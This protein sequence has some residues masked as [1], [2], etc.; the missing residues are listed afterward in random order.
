M[1]LASLLACTG[2]LPWWHE[3]SSHDTSADTAEDLCI[4]GC[5]C[6]AAAIT[7]GGTVSQEDGR[8]IYAPVEDDSAATMIHGPQGGWHVLASALAANTDDIIEI[9]YSITVDETATLVSWNR[10]YVQ[11]VRSDECSA[12][13][14]G[15]Y[16]YLDVTTLASG[17]ADTPP[18]LLA[19]K[20]LTLRMDV[21]DQT[22][23][24]ATDELHVVAALDAADEPD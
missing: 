19:G 6:D 5:F 15:M 21:T 18:E 23:R 12:Y 4:D 9:V 22:G 8:R 2:G 10:Y 1:L 7:V 3:G 11:M 20:G 14:P 13:Y 16:G 24:K 17:D